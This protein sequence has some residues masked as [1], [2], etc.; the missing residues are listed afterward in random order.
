MNC[1][2]EA[3]ILEAL[4]RKPW[5]TVLEILAAIPQKEILCPNYPLYCLENRSIVEARW[6]K[7]DGFVNRQYEYCLTKKPP[8]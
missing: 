5:M 1:E 8:I 2:N 4:K 3:A 6:R 7:D